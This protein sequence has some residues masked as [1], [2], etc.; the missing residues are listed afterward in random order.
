LRKQRGIEESCECAEEHARNVEAKKR[1]KKRGL[2]NPT[3]PPKRKHVRT[4]MVPSD[5]S[6][7]ESEEE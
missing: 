4:L 1:M 2:V 5:S 6:D 7:D 3:L